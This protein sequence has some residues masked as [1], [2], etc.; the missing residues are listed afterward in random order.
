MFDLDQ[1]RRI[2]LAP[3]AVPDLNRVCVSQKIIR[4]CR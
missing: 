1:T 4:L 2:M 3:E